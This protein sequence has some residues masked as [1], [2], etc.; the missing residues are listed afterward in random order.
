MPDPVIP[1]VSLA[2]TQ[3]QIQAATASSRDA[4]AVGVLGVDVALIAAAIPL[5]STL[6]SDWWQSLI[7]LGVSGLLA[8]TALLQAGVDLKL[9]PWR[10][11]ELSGDLTEEDV[12][13][14]LIG[15][16]NAVVV[17]T[18]RRLAVK[19][20][21]LTGSHMRALHSTMMSEQAIPEKSLASNAP[22]NSVEQSHEQPRVPTGPLP[23]FGDDLSS[24]EVPG[25]IPSWQAIVRT[26]RRLRPHSQ[27]LSH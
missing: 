24:F 2:E 25:V 15:L 18:N 22:S 20:W 17:K 4:I 16:I 12:A 21:A 5:R 13:L 3:L 6:G 19:T 8:L 26:L 14:R 7:A 11:Y 1:I 9:T 23:S 27:S 10:I